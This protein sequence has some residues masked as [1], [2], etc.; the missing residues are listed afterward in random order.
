M[1][2]DPQTTLPFTTICKE[3][4]YHDDDILQKKSQS[5]YKKPVKSKPQ[6]KK[7]IQ[8]EKIANKQEESNTK[9]INA[10]KLLTNMI[11]KVR[12]KKHLLCYLFQLNIQLHS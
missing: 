2:E 12:R 10:R 8:R 6:R 7:H 11:I 3:N 4:G 1:K 5:L 9:D